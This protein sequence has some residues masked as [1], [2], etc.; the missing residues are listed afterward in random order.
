MVT[1]WDV[2]I[3]WSL[4]LDFFFVFHQHDISVSI[5]IVRIRIARPSYHLHLIV[6]L[7][8]GLGASGERLAILCSLVDNRHIL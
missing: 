1:N 7:C 2:T 3:V 5:H 8:A 4:L 6:G